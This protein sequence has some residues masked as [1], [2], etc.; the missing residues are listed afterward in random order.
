MSDNKEFDNQDFIS[1]SSENTE[2]PV[3]SAP[4]SDDNG[5]I[6]VNENTQNSEA[7]LAEAKSQQVDINNLIADINSSTDAQLREPS[8]PVLAEADSSVAKDETK[9]ESKPE[10]KKECSMCPYYL[11][12]C[13]LLLWKCPKL[14]GAVFGSMFVLLLSFSLFSF[15]TVI[16]ALMLTALALVGAYRFYLAVVFRIKGTYD[17]SLDKLVKQDLPLPKDKIQECARLVEGDL[18]RALNQLKSIVLWE[19]VSQSVK[20][21]AAFYIVNW[22]GSCFNF[23][24][25]LL[26]G[27][28]TVFTLPKVYQVYKQPIDQSIQ[29]VTTLA[30]QVVKQVMVKIPMLNK[31]KTQ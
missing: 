7:E 3:P 10:D 20:A 30:H 21:F 26:I 24:T 11:L 6:V 25:L 28:V 22:V 27:L 18:Y 5:Y 29:K 12:V 23:L 19:S 16:S 4:T 8:S 9:N 31:K 2:A 17:D 1:S 15:L 14:T 13:D